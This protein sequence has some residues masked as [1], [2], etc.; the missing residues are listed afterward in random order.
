MHAYAK[1]LLCTILRTQIFQ[2]CKRVS[3]RTGSRDQSL[4]RVALQPQLLQQQ[5][6][7]L[8]EVPSSP[9]AMQFERDPIAD[10]KGLCSLG[11]AFQPSSRTYPPWLIC[12]AF[13]K[14]L[15][16]RLISLTRR[17]TS[18]MHVIVLAC[19]IRPQARKPTILQ[20]KLD[21]NKKSDK[22]KQLLGSRT[23]DCM[24]GP[25]ESC[26]VAT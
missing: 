26:F 7:L 11:F 10:G 20:D 19:P 13:F 4:L 25:E 8:R 15:A 17:R 14:S 23:S 21:E 24:N 2:S 12:L 5:L 22:A 6:L 1:Q 16:A 9:S 18:T 3:L